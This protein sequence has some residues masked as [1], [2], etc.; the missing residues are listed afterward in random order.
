MEAK[1]EDVRLGANRYRE[2]QPIGIAAQVIDVEAKL[3][4]VC[5]QINQDL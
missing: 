4:N 1:E 2:R 3:T 5:R